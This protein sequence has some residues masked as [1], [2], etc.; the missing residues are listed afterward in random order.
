MKFK[1]GD[2][3]IRTDTPLQEPLIII[4]RIV[5][6]YY[7]FTGLN[8]GETRRHSIKKVDTECP[9]IVVHS[10]DRNRFIRNVLKQL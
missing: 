2:L 6:D 5:E 9:W 10:N 7:E 3:L 4:S 8:T 1:V